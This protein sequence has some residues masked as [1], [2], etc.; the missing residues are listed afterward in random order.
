MSL[1]VK[2]YAGV[3]LRGTKPEAASEGP[4]VHGTGRRT[5]TF[6][7][8]KSEEK[9]AEFDGKWGKGGGVFCEARAEPGSI[10]YLFPVEGEC[11]G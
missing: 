11:L 9:E 8:L 4:V 1:I 7:G 5:G 3:S 2:W 10:E 6:V